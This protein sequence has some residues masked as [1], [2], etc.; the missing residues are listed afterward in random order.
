MRR[1]IVAITGASGA[2]LGLHALRLLRSLPEVETHLILSPSGIRTLVEE[3]G[4]GADAARALADHHHDHRDIGSALASGSFRTAG[5][6]VA[7]C[8]IKTLSAIAQSYDNDL[9]VRAA[10]V[11]L[12]ERRPVVLMVR[13]TPL[14]AGHLR[15]MQEVTANGAIVMPPV[16]A[17]YLRPVSVDALAE[18]LAARALDLLGFEVAALARWKDDPAPTPDAPA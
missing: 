13:E 2:C 3:T 10:D 11:C 7:P 15:L 9:I 4:Q 17:F 18:Q 5:M 12:K 6:L 14:H 1:I 8:S 16:P